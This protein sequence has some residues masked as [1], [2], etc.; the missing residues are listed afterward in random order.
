MRRAGFLAHVLASNIVHSVGLKWSSRIAALLGAI[1]H[2]PVLADVE[3]TRPGTAAPLIWPPLRN[4]VLETI[5]AGEAALLHRLHL[6]IHPLF[7]FREGL[8]L[9]TAVMNDANGRAETQL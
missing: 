3:V 1:V 4:V 6:V 7:F 5:N 9:P 2:Q 8:Q